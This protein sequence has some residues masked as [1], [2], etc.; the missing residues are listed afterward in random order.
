ML[1]ENELRNTLLDLALVSESGPWIRA[2]KSEHLQRRTPLWSR[3]P[4]EHGARFVPKGGFEAL[5]LTSDPQT[6]RL[7]VEAMFLNSLGNTVPGDRE[8]DW[9]LV[10]V[11]GTVE[12]VLDLM[13]SRIWKRLATSWQELTG[14][15][16]WSFDEPLPP[17]QLLGRVAYEARKI[18][19]IRYHSAKNPG[20]GFN[21][22]V[23]PDRLRVGGISHL[24]VENPYLGLP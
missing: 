14:L 4:L 8:A 6:A 11:E 2:V 23:F 13:D 9:D 10:R 21:L 3:G 16:R 20:K 19:G 7:E 17:T 1:P 12:N 5:H 15:W 24:E 22:V 18:F